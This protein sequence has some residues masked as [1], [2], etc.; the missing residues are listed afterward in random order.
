MEYHSPCHACH[1]SRRLDILFNVN[2]LRAHGVRNS[3]TQ[4]ATHYLVEYPDDGQIIDNRQYT[5]VYQ[6]RQLGR[7]FSWQLSGK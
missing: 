2:V 5:L 7:S 1:M 4:R 6:G 3:I